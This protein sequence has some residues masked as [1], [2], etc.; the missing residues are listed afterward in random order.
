M[1]K[2]LGNSPDALELIANYGADSVRVGLLLSSA[3]GNDLLFDEALCQQGKN[4]TNKVWNAFR[5]VNGWEVQ[6]IDQ[7]EAARQ[8]IAWYRARLAKAV[9]E[10][11]DHFG[12]YRISDALMVVYKLIWDDFCSWFLEIVKPAYQSPIDKASHKAV[13]EFFETNLILLHPFMPFLSEE[14]W[15]R[16]RDRKKDEALIISKWP[17]LTSGNEELISEFEFAASLITA[18]RNIRK[19]KNIPNKE[20]L[21]LR[22]IDKEKFNKDWNSIIIKLGHLASIEATD[23]AVEAALSF[24]VRSNE[25]FIPASQA[26]D[27]EAE[28]KKIKDEL[29]YTR[30]FLSSVEKKLSNERFVNN[31]PEKVVALEKKKAADAQAKIETLEKSLSNLE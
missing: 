5:L 25:Y 17:E 21:D 10:V 3:A 30:G 24:R 9:E 7:S 18:I 14:I 23:T 26:V 20:V 22:V 13:I 27:L 12:K 6:D 1:S 16:I 4:F 28:K 11:N 19:E 15:Q 2:S 8:G 29:E 31:A